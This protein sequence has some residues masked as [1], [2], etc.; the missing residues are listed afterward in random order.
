[1]L[2]VGLPR[3]GGGGNFDRN[4][5]QIRSRSTKTGAK[6]IHNELSLCT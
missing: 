1:M 6:L 5:T 3:G 2:I 4:L